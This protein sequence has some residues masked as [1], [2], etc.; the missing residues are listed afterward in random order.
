MV[1]HLSRGFQEPEWKHINLLRPGL[2]TVT[3]P[4]LPPSLSQR[5]SR[6]K[7]RSINR[8]QF[9][10]GKVRSHSTRGYREENCIQFCS[11]STTCVMFQFN[12]IQINK[13]YSTVL[14]VVRTRW[15]FMH[16]HSIILF[17]Y[18]YLL[19]VFRFCLFWGGGGKGLLLA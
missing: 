6:V 2:G 15:L 13:T 5:D 9:L 8:F 4:L 12:N 1:S 14:T 7:K 10:I 17:A 11:E 18:F 16:I 19:R 3:P